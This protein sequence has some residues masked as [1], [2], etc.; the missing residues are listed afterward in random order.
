MRFWNGSQSLIYE[1][2]ADIIKMLTDAAMTILLLLLM[3]YERIGGAVHEWLGIAIFTLFILHHILNAGWTA[4]LFKGRYP[5]FRIMRTALAGLVFAA[6]PGSMI[7]GIMLSRHA[8]AFLRIQSG[9]SFARNL[10]ML[11]AYWGFV[12]ISVHLGLHQSVFIGLAKRVVKA[13]NVALKWTARAAASVI[14]GYGVYAFI[15]RDIGSYMLLKNQF[16]FID[17]EEP[18]ILF[19]LDYIAIMGLFIAVGHYLSVLTKRLDKRDNKRPCSR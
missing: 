15:K 11:S 6:M 18:L 19:L 16:V 7:S 8:F 17:F 9:M 12:L 10:H 3:T 14:S 1:A 4:V 5:T 13:K 2:E